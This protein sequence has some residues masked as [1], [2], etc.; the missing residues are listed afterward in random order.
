VI[1]LAALA[2][3]GA[4]GGTFALTRPRQ[5]AAAPALPAIADAAV[6]PPLVPPDAAPAPPDAGV[7]DAAPPP[8]DAAPPDARTRRS[9][10]PRP[11]DDSGR[12]RDDLDGDGIPDV[13]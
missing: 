1:M 4:A 2:L 13:R 7:P 8:A 3:A 5:P 9:T 12:H 6:A 10:R 11:D